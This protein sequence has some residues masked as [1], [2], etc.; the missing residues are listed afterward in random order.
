MSR[1]QIDG[2]ALKRKLHSGASNLAEHLSLINELNVFP[3]PDGDTG[4]NM[5]HTLQRALQEIAALETDDASQVAERFAYGALM[6]ARGNSGTILSQLLG[7]FAD[8][9]EGRP[10]LSAPHLPPALQCAVERAYEAVSQPVEG[11][12]LTVAR[13]SVAQ[14]DSR[15]GDA[16]T[17]DE[18]FDALIV[19]AEQSLERTPSLL[20]LLREAGVV[21][22]GGM[23]LLCFLRGM[24]AAACDDLPAAAPV[25]VAA[26]SR[27]IPLSIA[28]GGYGYDVQ[29]LMRGEHQDLAA[30]RQ[31]LG[32]LG[33]SVVVVGDATAIKVHIHVDNPAIPIDYAIKSGAALDDVVVENMSLQ[34]EAYR[35]DRPAVEVGA[36]HDGAPELAV[37]A[38]AQG[39]GLQAIFRQL[40]CNTV[41]DGGAGHSPSTEDFVHAIRQLPARDVV[42]LPND[43]NIQMAAQQA[44]LFVSEKQ[45]RVLPTTTIQQGI[46]AMI[47]FGDAVDSR[48]D[49]ATTIAL[50]REAAAA[51]R[52]I[53]LTR[54]TRATVLRGK[55]ISQGDYIA[56]ADDGI[57]AAGADVHDVALAALKLTVNDE[58]E[59][60]TVYHGV[61]ISKR[62]AGQLIAHLSNGINA[63]EY[64]LVF[65]GQDLYP[66][67]ISIE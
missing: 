18:M 26:T 16:L 19:G 20:P 64:E 9:L 34:A 25:A 8:G 6:G 42:L 63:L 32:Q 3:V 17:L 24:R 55:S 59:L 2:P 12:M 57:I 28:P 43:R 10:I 41:I 48:A 37:A 66:Y 60:A 47:A 52:S 29:F 27:L 54:A 58:A 49:P 50:M 46:N 62:A 45:V 51:V 22:A 23:G 1:N 14:L 30:I 33:D 44:A 67:L 39:A 4:T 15:R 5:H 35:R 21:D 56:L 7:G 36:R 11:T 38:V 31:A 65:G 61:G 40:H 53:G 13:E